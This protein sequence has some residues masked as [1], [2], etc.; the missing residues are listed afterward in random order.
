MEA[1]HAAGTA[2]ETRAPLQLLAGQGTD[3]II[4]PP[5]PYYVTCHRQEVPAQMVASLL[6]IST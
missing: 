1:G 2:A 3:I 6:V 5:A 4:G